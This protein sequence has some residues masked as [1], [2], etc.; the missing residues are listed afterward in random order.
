MLGTWRQLTNPFNF[1]TVTRELNQKIKFNFGGK[2]FSSFYHV[3][4]RV[5]HTHTRVFAIYDIILCSSEFQIA[6]NSGTDR[7]IWKF[8]SE[9]SL[10]LFMIGDLLNFKNLSW[11]E[12]IFKL[13]CRRTERH[14]VIDLNDDFAWMF[15]SE[16][17]NK[18]FRKIFNTWEF[19]RKMS[20]WFQIENQQKSKA[21]E[22]QRREIEKERKRK[23]MNL[24]ASLLG[25]EDDVSQT[26]DSIS[27]VLCGSVPHNQKMKILSK[28]KTSSFIFTHSQH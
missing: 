8:G 18:R 5:Q 12:K 24:V 19:N 13:S 4:M 14:F 27:Y 16:E 1:V 15:T 25:H 28:K 11:R 26:N 10:Q 6:I 22:K 23:R 9:H 20:T 2:I 3:W 21:S 7:T 17:I